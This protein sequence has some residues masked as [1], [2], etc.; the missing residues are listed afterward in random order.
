MQ[1]SIKLRPH[2]LSEVHGNPLIVKSI[3]NRAKQGAWPT[4]TLL[5]GYSGCGK[6]TISNI[7]AN[8]INCSNPAPN[9]DPCLSCPSCRS[10]TEER[11]DRDIKRLDGGQS[12]KDDVL[13]FT[14][15]IS[16]VPFYDRRRSVFI[17]EEIDQL[18]SK[19]TN[20]LLKVLETPQENVHFILLSMSTKGVDLPNNSRCQTYSFSPFM[21]KDILLGLQSDMKK[22]GVW[23]KEDIPKSFYTEVLPAIASA[24]SGSYRKALQDMESCLYGEAWSPEAYSE[25]TGALDGETVSDILLELLSKRKG[26]FASL[27]RINFQEFFNLSYDILS[28]AFAFKVTGVIKNDFFEDQIKSLSS[29]PNLESLLAVFNTIYETN[30]SYTKKSHAFYKFAQY[31]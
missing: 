21:K 31:Y 25:L 14:Q 10:V 11:Y 4:A 3:Y 7:L 5:K 16:S 8:M 26:V 17:I 20:A 23:G 30:P 28:K 2:I 9:G 22:M 13:D 1:N 15:M 19:A 29:N 6:S 27:E 24:S 18:S 12:G